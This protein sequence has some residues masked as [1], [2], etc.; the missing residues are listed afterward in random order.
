MAQ[1]TGTADR[2]SAPAPAAFLAGS[3]FAVAAMATIIILALALGMSVTLREG[4]A[5]AGAGKAP[6][7]AGVSTYDGRLDPI[8]ADYIRNRGR[9]PRT[10]EQGLVVDTPRGGILYTG[11]PY[12]LPDTNG[13]GGSNGTRFPQ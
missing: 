10:A 1:H 11:I 2:S 3:L 9:A 8:E 5:T 13:S 6:P 7:A 4:A 12:Q